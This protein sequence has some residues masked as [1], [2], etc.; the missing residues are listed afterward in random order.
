MQTEV[1]DKLNELLTQLPKFPGVQG[2]DNIY[3]AMSNL[4]SD[5][6][7][8]FPKAYRYFLEG[9]KQDRKDESD[10][11]LKMFQSCLLNCQEPF[12]VLQLHCLLRLGTVYS[13]IGQL[14]HSSNCYQKVLKRADALDSASLAIAYSNISD[15]FLSLEDYSRVVLLADKG[16]HCSR[17][18]KD[19]VSA[20]ICLSNRAMAQANLQRYANAIESINRSMEL[21]QKNGSAQFYAIAHSYRSRILSMQDQIP[22][23]QVHHNFLESHRLLSDIHD[24]YQQTF[25]LIIFSEYLMAKEAWDKLSEVRL[26]FPKEKYLSK[27]KKLLARYYQI[28]IELAKQDKDDDVLSALKRLLE[29][30]N[31]GR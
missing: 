24:D 31:E 17:V 13:D 5:T 11:A 27:N 4:C 26:L 9:V 14:N 29:K 18:A 2:V 25:N 8:E 10:E 30:L 22:L 21:A 12:L 1:L 6:G 19:W 3:K 15:L 23:E 7:I 16:I 20:V 28:C